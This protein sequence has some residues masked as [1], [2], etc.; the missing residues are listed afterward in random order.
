MHPSRGIL[1]LRQYGLGFMPEAQQNPA[2]CSENAGR[3]PTGSNELFLNGASDMS[4][5]REQSSPVDGARRAFVTASISA[6]FAAAV[7]PALGSTVIQTDSSGLDVGETRFAAG[8]IEMLAYYAK[9]KDGRNLPIVLL[10]QEIFGLHEHIRDLVRRLG[11]AGYLAIAPNLYQRQGDPTAISDINQLVQTIVANVPDAQVFR[12]LDA[13]AVW[14][15]GHGGDL[16]KLAV[17][18]F[19]WGGRITWLYSAY[20][21]AVKAGVAWYGRL[22]GKANPLQPLYPVDV[23]AQLNAPVL[24]LYGE[25]DGGIPLESVEKMRAALQ[26]AGKPSEIIVYPKAP[27][28]FNADYRPSYVSEFAADGWQR[29]LAWF[30]QNGVG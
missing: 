15:G 5:T 4:T 1:Q 14:A 8:D 16:N 20:S 3:L 10:V 24:G 23:A 9:P 27:H 17:T 22:V 6:G 13:A 7:A 28:G 12:D 19:C 11:K 30:R 2:Q 29:M 21:P 25:A 26:A 18:G